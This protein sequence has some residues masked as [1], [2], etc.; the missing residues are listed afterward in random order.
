MRRRGAYLE[1]GDIADIVHSEVRVID[2]DGH[3]VAREI[4]SVISKEDDAELGA[5]RHFMQK[6]IFEQPLAVARTAGHVHSL[7]TAL[8]GTAAPEMLTGVERVLMLGCGTSHY[9]ALTARGWFERLAGIPAH[10]EISSEFRYRDHVKERG[11]LVVP[12]SQSGETA[13]TLAALRYAQSMG[14]AL[15]LTI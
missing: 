12:I 8:F 2:P 1:D 5:Y 4:R 14:E 15:T 10:A 7:D 3:E 9:A 6:E 11:T 13:D